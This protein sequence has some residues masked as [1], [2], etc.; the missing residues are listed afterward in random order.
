MGPQKNSKKLMDKVKRLT[1]YH[2]AGHAVVLRATSDFQKVDRV[3]I[4]P[5]GSQED[6]QHISL[7]RISF[8]TEKML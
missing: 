2:E 1:A 7:L 8:Y 6:I 4:I 5:A 3:A